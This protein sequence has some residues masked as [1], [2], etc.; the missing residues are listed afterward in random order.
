VEAAVTGTCICWWCEEPGTVLLELYSLG[1]TKREWFCEKDAKQFQGMCWTR[2]SPN[3]GG[4][5]EE[6]QLALWEGD[7]G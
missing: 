4:N 1:E 6:P 7:A 3:S 5:D 2:V